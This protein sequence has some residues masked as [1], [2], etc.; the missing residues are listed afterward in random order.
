[1]DPETRAY[2]NARPEKDQSGKSDGLTGHALPAVRIP[3]STGRTA[4]NQYDSNAL[5]EMR[6]HFHR[7]RNGLNRE[8]EVRGGTIEPADESGGTCV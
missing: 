2:G 8:T 1:L 5:P 6:R 7:K 4:P 3:D